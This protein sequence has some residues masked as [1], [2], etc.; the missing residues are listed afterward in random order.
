[1]LRCIK[2]ENS[3]F[4]PRL[5]SPVSKEYPIITGAWKSKYGKGGCLLPDF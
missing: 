5:A 2:I 1:M 3:S 4:S